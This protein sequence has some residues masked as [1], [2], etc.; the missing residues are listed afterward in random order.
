MDKVRDTHAYAEYTDL[1]KKVFDNCEIKDNVPQIKE[2]YNKIIQQDNSQLNIYFPKVEEHTA[3][4]IAEEFMDTIFDI[5]LKCN[6]IKLNHYSWT[7]ESP[8]RNYEKEYVNQT[9][10]NTKQ[11]LIENEFFRW[12]T[13][14]SIKAIRKLIKIVRYDDNLPSNSEWDDKGEFER[15]A[16]FELVKI[17]KSAWI[18][19]VEDALKEVQ[20]K[21]REAKLFENKRNTQIYERLQ[22]EL[23][24]C[25]IKEFEALKSEKKLKI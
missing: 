15:L 25:S 10:E 22:Y 23:R 19:N 8:Y 14:Y 2:E 13:E 11:I 21:L 20:K 9:I 5:K 12:D 3:V 1:L 16:L 4:K 6:K 18:V 24:E 7:E 17:V